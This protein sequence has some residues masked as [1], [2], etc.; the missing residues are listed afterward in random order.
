[1]CDERL[2]FFQIATAQRSRVL[3]LSRSSMVQETDGRGFG[4]ERDTSL[5]LRALGKI[6]FG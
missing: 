5:V 1:M 6:D 3:F 2:C 4:V